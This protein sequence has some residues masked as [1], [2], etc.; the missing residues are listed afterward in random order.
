MGRDRGQGPVT[1][2]WADVDGGVYIGP[3]RR[4]R[5][6]SR[7]GAGFAGRTQYLMDPTVACPVLRGLSAPSLFPRTVRSRQHL[8]LRVRTRSGPFLWPS[9]PLPCRRMPS[10]APAPRAMR[11]GLRKRL[12]LAR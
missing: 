9:D 11:M 7:A 4:V 1:S 6:A 2:A 12:A 8:V 3:P 10:T 5:R